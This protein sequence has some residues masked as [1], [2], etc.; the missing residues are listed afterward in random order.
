MLFLK[1]PITVSMKTGGVA[2]VL[3]AA[4]FLLGGCTLPFFEDSQLPADSGQVEGVSADGNTAGGVN[5]PPLSGV[6]KQ[7]VVLIVGASESMNEIMD[8]ERKIDITKRSL[9]NYVKRL[10]PETNLSI[11]VY[12]HVG[13]KSEEDKALSC[14]TITEKYYLGPLNK[15]VAKRRINTISAKGWAPIASALEQA[16]V[17][18]SAHP[19]EDNRIV[20]VSDGAETCGGDPV[21]MARKI[22]KDRV[23]VDVLGFAV[24]DAA[25]IELTNIAIRGGG[26]YISAKNASELSVATNRSGLSMLTAGTV[27]SVRTDGRLRVMMSADSLEID[28]DK[29]DLQTQ[30]GAVAPV[31]PNQLSQESVPGI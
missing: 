2:V 1:T 7:N 9:G 12:G 17:I 16:S 3:V 31:P 30:D 15:A 4:V 22:H 13:S 11:L 25:A 26:G 27:V 19:G 8:G 5:T 23:R 18:L 21:A 24:E 14:G 20:L 28:V 29:L 10:M 6:A